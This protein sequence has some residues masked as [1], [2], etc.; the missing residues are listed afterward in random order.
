V[1]DVDVDG[2]SGTICGLATELTPARMTTVLDL[3]GY[4]LLP[5]PV[6]PH[7]HL[8]KAFLAERIPNPKGDLLGAIEA[9]EASRAG[10]TVEDNAE[11]AERALRLLIANGTTVVR[12]HADTTLANGLRSIEGLA[13]AR[14]RVADLVDLQIVALVSW[15]IVGPS[16]ADQRALLRDALAAGADVVGGCPHLDD[17]PSGANEVLL[18]M[19]AEAGRMIDLHTDETLDPGVLGV[20][21]LAARVAKSGFPH[22][23]TASHCV[24]L[25]VQPLDVQEAVAEEIATA[26]VSVVTLPQT[27]LFLQGRDHIVAVPRG[28]TALRPLLS[29][30]ANLAGGADNLQDP[31]NLVGR[32][33]PLET[34]ALLV[35][36][37]HL[38]P[39][40]AYHAVSVAARVALGLPPVAIEPG[41]PAELLAVRA[42]T[43]REAVASA[44]PDRVV[45]HRGRIV[46]RTRVLSE[47]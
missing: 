13:K 46:S 24:S 42:N 25:G 23:V 32:A 5:A 20:R 3:H 4:L 18:D 43:L 40:E 27:N 22:A 35:M 11:R 47:P 6:E 16:G 39:D 14:E 37:G 34:A 2:G 17:D 33:D 10:L 30:G 7:A 45:I 44:P 38:T 36:A 19:A 1:V 8:D 31:F 9:M 21:D 29:A 41:A 28:L 15:P 26:G 12:S